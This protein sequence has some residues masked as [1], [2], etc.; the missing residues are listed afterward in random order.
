MVHAVHNSHP[1]S[2][3]CCGLVMPLICM[4]EHQLLVRGSMLILEG[5][6]EIRINWAKDYVGILM[7]PIVKIKAGMKWISLRAWGRGIYARGRQNNSW[8]RVQMNES[9]VICPLDVKGDYAN[10]LIPAGMWTV[11]EVGAAISCCKNDCLCQ[12]LVD[13]APPPPQ[14][15]LGITWCVNKVFML[16]LTLTGDLKSIYNV[17]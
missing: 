8:P 14:V 15:S 5:L 12:C 10:V 2:T 6:Q 13:N 4:Q 1:H 11:L 3:Q 9:L 7:E 17:E 16:S